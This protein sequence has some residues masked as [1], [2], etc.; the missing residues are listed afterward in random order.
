MFDELCVVLCQWLVKRAIE[1]REE[2][3]DYVRAYSISQFQ[4]SHSLPEVTDIQH[5]DQD[6]A[7]LDTSLYTKFIKSLKEFSC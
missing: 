4:K 5:E 6:V 1:T 2:M 3:G 7:L